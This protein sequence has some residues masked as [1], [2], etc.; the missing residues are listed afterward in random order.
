M[1]KKHKSAKSKARKI[2]IPDIAELV[3]ITAAIKAAELSLSEA[4]D[5]LRRAKLTASTARNAYRIATTD[6]ERSLLTRF[7]LMQVKLVWLSTKSTVTYTC[8]AAK[9]AEKTLIAIRR[10]LKER[11]RAA[12]RERK[13]ARERERAAAR[14]AAKKAAKT[15]AVAA[16]KASARVSSRTPPRV[17]AKMVAI[18]AIKAAKR[19]K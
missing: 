11:K 17:A 15:V 16:A 10:V 9:T 13:R 12:A 1:T 5:T 6:H 2:N 14:K 8:Y 18:A 19:Y 7:V 4:K 3:A